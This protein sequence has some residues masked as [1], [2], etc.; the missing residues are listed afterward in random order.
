HHMAAEAFAEV[1]R[2]GVESVGSLRSRNW[3]K[4]SEITTQLRLSLGATFGAWSR[5]I[6][7]NELRNALDGARLSGDRLLEALPVGEQRDQ[8]NDERLQQMIGQIQ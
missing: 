2:M 3:N 5:L 1:A 7:D 4:V 8:I 6:R